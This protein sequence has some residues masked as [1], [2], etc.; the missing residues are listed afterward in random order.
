MLGIGQVQLTD[1]ASLIALM[2]GGAA[3]A[4]AVIMTRLGT[5]RRERG[6]NTDRLSLVGA[7]VQGVA[8]GLT[9]IRVQPGPAADWVNAAEVA[10]LMAASVALFAWSARTMGRNWAIVARTRGEHELVTTGPF[11]FVRNPIY[12]AM[13]LFMLAVAMATRHEP[14]LIA[15]APLF[16][17]GTLIR[18]T[19]EERLLRTQFGPAYDAYAARVK[20]FIPGVV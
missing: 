7:I 10:L 12:V 20:R 19:I 6:G 18:T 1:K 14:A 11:A 8:I 16:V 3:F 17:I 2:I 9:A 13:F 4:G 5:G 15:T